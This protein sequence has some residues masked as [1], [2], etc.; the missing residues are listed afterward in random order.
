MATGC[1]FDQDMLESTL[2]IATAANQNSPKLDYCDKNDTSEE[3]LG[4]KDSLGKL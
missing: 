4:F 1:L 3:I 2:L